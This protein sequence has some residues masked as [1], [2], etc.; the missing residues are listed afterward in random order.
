MNILKQ[1]SRLV[2][3]FSYIRHNCGKEPPGYVPMVK[4][5][6]GAD[7]LPN[8]GNRYNT[9]LGF[10]EP[11]NHNEDPETIAYAWLKVIWLF[12]TLKF[13]DQDHFI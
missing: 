3:L 11:Y 12:D 8:I 1:H 6:N 5:W 9:V 7:H 4:R 10:N 2:V 13:Y